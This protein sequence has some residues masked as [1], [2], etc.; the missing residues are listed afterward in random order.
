MPWRLFFDAFYQIFDDAR[1]I[2]Y[3]RI[4]VVGPGTEKM[5]NRYHF[6]VDLMPEE[7]DYIAEGLTRAFDRE[8]VSLDNLKCLWVK[9]EQT[10]EVI[11]QY[12]KEKSAILDQAIAYRTVPE[13]DDPT[14][15]QARFKEE[16][17]DIITFTSALTVECFLDLGLSVPEGCLIASMGPI[18]S[19]QIRENSYE[20]D[21]EPAQST[22]PQFVDAIV[23]HFE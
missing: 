4:A 16:G 5:V 19:E 10:R 3:T 17:A 21:I 6:A 11:D 1:S 18:T 20:V 7:G 2:G 15:S 13:T 8:G 14:G 9:G 12:M 23:D 22:I